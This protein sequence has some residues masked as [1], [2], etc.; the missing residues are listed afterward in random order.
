MSNDCDDPL[1]TLIDAGIS[2]DASEAAFLD[3]LSKSTVL[4]ILR[5][6]P[7]PGDATPGRNLVEWK[8]ADGRRI[9]PLFTSLARALPG[10]PAPATYVRVQM[11][12]LLL[13]AG[14]RRFVIN[15]LS[16]GKFE[17][18]D[19]AYRQLQAIAA[20]DPVLGEL[21]SPDR[22]WE[23][24]FPDDSLYPVAY[25]LASWFVASGRVDEAYLYELRL[26]GRNTPPQVVLAVNE[27]HDSALADALVQ[28][29]CSAGLTEE[30]FRVRFLPEEPS[31]RSGISSL[32][33]EP[34]YKR[35]ASA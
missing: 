30:A 28:I 11:L 32:H 6:P 17:L 13:S 15:P 8:D 31:H 24:R 3:L 1:G 12:V 34:F 29:A 23:F 25:A 16:P 10:L 9:V 20:A 14:A 21:P 5:R 27:Q 7:G 35:P 18:S 4:V 2:S 22:P 26:P 33:L 19:S